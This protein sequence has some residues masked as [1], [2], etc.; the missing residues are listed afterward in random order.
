MDEHDNI[1]QIMPVPSNQ[2]IEA[3]FNDESSSREF[4]RPVVGLALVET[5]YRDH[6]FSS[7]SH[8]PNYVD[9]LITCNEDG[10]VH[11]A[12]DMEGFIKTRTTIFTP[13]TYR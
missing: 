2:M 11:L 13:P 5:K 10:S 4:T 6:S 1:I 12:S 7:N 8:H 3:I 9:F